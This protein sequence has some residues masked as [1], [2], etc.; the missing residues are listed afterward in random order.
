MGVACNKNMPS[1]QDKNA[2]LTEAID[3]ISKV[4]K[5]ALD[6]LKAVDDYNEARSPMVLTRALKKQIKYIILSSLTFFILF[7]I[8]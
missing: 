4:M 1:E 3:N 2:I 5:V 8:I 6:K 7:F